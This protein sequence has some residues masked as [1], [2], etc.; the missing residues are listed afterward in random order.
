MSSS[1]YT[2]TILVDKTPLEVFT[3]I[4][5]VKAWKHGEIIVYAQKL[6]DEFSNKIEEF[7]FSNQIVVDLIPNLKIV[8]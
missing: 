6:I 8:W 7:H 1:N 3:S 2:T 5:N 4:N